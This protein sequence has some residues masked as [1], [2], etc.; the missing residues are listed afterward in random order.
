MIN[1]MKTI[2]AILIL[3]AVATL[4]GCK[5]SYSVQSYKAPVNR[6]KPEEAV[7]IVVP[8]DAYDEPGSGLVAANTLRLT[9]STHASRIEL[10]KQTTA[11][12]AHLTTAAAGGFTYVLD[13]T[14]HS[15]E[16][17]PT[18]WTGK[19]DQVDMTLRLLHAP[20]GAVTSETRVR[21]NSKWMTFGGDHVEDLLNPL[22]SGWVQAIYEGTDFKGP[23]P[24]TKAKK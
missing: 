10:S 8:P 4:M 24:A 13:T 1:F 15:W 9:F 11:P 20:D 5:S 19:S 3:I 6:P 21:G 17:E 12:D 2:K 7:Y 22:A 23:G 16:E 18:E 14:I